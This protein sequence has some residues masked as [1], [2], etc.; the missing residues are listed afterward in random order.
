M[1][2]MHSTLGGTQAITVIILIIISLILIMP[3]QA[4]AALTTSLPTTSILW[5]KEL[6]SRVN[7]ISWSPDGSRIAASLDSGR[8]I[9]LSEDGTLL[10]ET[11]LGAPITGISWRPDG[12]KLVI[13]VGHPNGK[14][15]VI[16]SKGTV[17]WESSTGGVSSVSWG[18]HGSAIAVG[19]GNRV[20]LFDP[21]GEILWEDGML[22]GPV[23]SVSWSP[24]GS[25]IAAGIN[26]DNGMGSR[27]R[28]AILD[29]RGGELWGEDL[30][31]Q[32][33]HVSWSPDGLRIAAGLSDGRIVT[34]DSSGVLLREMK[35]GAPI[36]GISWSP[37]GGKLAASA[38]Y[39]ITIFSANGFKLQDYY[40]GDTVSSIAWS[41][42]DSRL[43]A[44][45][46]YSLVVF[47]LPYEVSDASMGDR[48]SDMGI[49]IL[50]FAGFGGLAALYIVVKRGREAIQTPPTPIT[51]EEQLVSIPTDGNSSS[52]LKPV[53]SLLGKSIGG[54]KNMSQCRDAYTMELPEP[55]APQGYEGSWSCCKLGCGGWGCAYRCMRPSGGEPI[56]F[57]VP[58]GME[59]LLEEG[60]I[61]TVDEHILER[62]IS[63]ASTVSRLS[64]PHI[65][66]LLAYSRRAPILV[67]EYADMG[68][69]DQQLANGWRPGMK[70]AVLAAIQLGDALRYIHSRG[71]IHGDIKPGNI[72]VR[73]SVVKLGDF[74]SLVRLITLT[75]RSP[76]S[77]TPGWRAPEQAY[78]DLRLRAMKAGLENRIDVYQ[79]GNLLLYLLTGK[80]I[81]GE[82]ATSMASLEKALARVGHKGLREV[83][84][85]M[86]ALEPEERPSI[87]QAITQLYK[88]YTTPE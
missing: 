61:Q 77:H 30:D 4:G 59:A 23:S 60:T 80:T 35:L 57:K 83:L 28:V 58:R 25:M 29:S 42:R 72:F 11:R 14:V 22:G 76:L 78:S 73:G 47:K 63:E 32:V 5:E 68:S 71:L 18:P 87:E 21:G 44:G 66:R 10:W 26:Q 37:D 39:R 45:I 31:G 51:Q 38:G 2:N 48:V 8:V 36:T 69:L 84:R 55:I 79:L 46:G 53:A 1:S 65:L 74:S 52:S 82:E 27:G 64:H 43:A 6:G 40:P 19:A 15:V 85:G 20:M 17:V 33:K 75:S 88:I 50:G 62:V 34:F 7:S 56:V 49:I 9:V 67:Y 54:F 86:L 24:D 12:S 3:D 70:D 13:G 81:D 41:P 16:D